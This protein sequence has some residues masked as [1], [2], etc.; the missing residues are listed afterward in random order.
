MIRGSRGECSH[1][2]EKKIWKERGRNDAGVMGYGVRCASIELT[3]AQEPAS[4]RLN[5]VALF[6]GI[7]SGRPRGQLTGK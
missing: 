1:A 4:A 5:Q 3:A 6:F 7:Y 2:D